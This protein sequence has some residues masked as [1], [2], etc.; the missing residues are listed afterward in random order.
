MTVRTPNSILDQLEELKKR[1]DPG[2]IPSIE[3]TLARLTR[4]KFND[5]EALV[6]Y[7]E[8]LLFLR[9]YPQNSRI[10][11]LVDKELA[12]FSR[13]VE[14]LQAFGVDRSTIETPEISGIAGSSVTDTFTLSDCSLAGTTATGSRGPGLGLVRR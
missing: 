7:H 10:V 2:V 1:F 14:A 6:R 4:Q 8:L 12:S 13:R 11:N 9:A 3:K 5:A